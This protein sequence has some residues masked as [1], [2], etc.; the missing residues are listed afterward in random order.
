MLAIKLSC[1]LLKYMNNQERINWM[2]KIALLSQG[3]DTGSRKQFK[4][5]SSDQLKLL[6]SSPLVTIGAHTINHPSLARLSFEE[7][8]REVIGSKEYL[9]NLLGTKITEFAYPFGSIDD[10]TIDPIRILKKCGIKKAFTTWNK[11]ISTE[12]NYEIPRRSICECELFQFKQILSD[13]F[14][15]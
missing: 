13:P 15:F 12:K 5:L 9:E 10:Y 11:S 14:K 7:Q 1:R 6:Y 4:M 2:N 3:T 8:I